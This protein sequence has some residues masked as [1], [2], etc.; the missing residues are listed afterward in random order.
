MRESRA[1]DERMPAGAPAIRLDRQGM[2]FGVAALLAGLHAALTVAVLLEPAISGAVGFGQTF[3]LLLFSLLHGAALWGGRRLGL[4]FLLAVGLAWALEQVGVA[5]GWVYG[6]Y[7]Y[8]RM[9]GPWLGHVPLLIPLAWFM[10]LYPSTVIAHLIDTGQPAPRSQ[11]WRHDVWLA[12]LA[13]LVMAAWDLALDPVMVEHGMWVWERPGPYFGVPIQNYVGWVVTGFL[14]VLLARRLWHW[15][16]WR[17]PSAVPAWAV[18]LP[19]LVY[20]SVMVRFFSRPELGL[21]A[22]FAM[23]FPVLIAGRR[24]LQGSP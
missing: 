18:G 1:M 4:F 13:G 2:A 24:W 9:A 5:T 16:R 19:L 8:E 14:I 20:A 6:G 15:G 23:G 7:R 3:L 10:M 11:G 12:L 22:A 21:I 17:T